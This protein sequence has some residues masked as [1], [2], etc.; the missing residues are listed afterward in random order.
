M[1]LKIDRRD[2]LVISGA[3]AGCVAMRSSPLR[4][5]TARLQVVGLKIDNLDRPF[6]L[7]NSRPRLSWYLESNERNVRQ[8]AYRI[9]V[10]RS[11]AP[12][13]EERGELWDSGKIDCR[14]SFGVAYQGREL[15]P[16]QRCW[17]C[18]QVWDEKGNLSPWSEIGEWEMGL[19]T[20]SDWE[21]QWLAAED[22]VA[23]ADREAG[24]NWICGSAPQD[25][26]ARK[27]RLTFRLPAPA[28]Q[29]VL[30]V[31]GQD[32]SPSVWIDGTP[33]PIEVPA[34]NASGA[35]LAPE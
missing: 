6:G 10:A 15:T 32:R 20:A 1:T 12:L 33:L 34:A 21:A 2:F 8:S 4:A 29:G 18:V 30:F 25:E 35:G 16:R 3:P 14:K 24:L 17:W 13:Q 31:G 7:E 28:R 23:K 27:F 26:T 22:S 9:L 11:E 5:N 19:L